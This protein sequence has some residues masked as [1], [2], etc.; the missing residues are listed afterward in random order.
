[1][2][3][4]DY[5]I[6]TYEAFDDYIDETEP[7][8][9]VWGVTWSPSVAFERID[10]IG[11]RVAMSDWLS[12]MEVAEQYCPDCDLFLWDACACDSPTQRGDAQ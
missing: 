11:Y 4:M 3:K 10:P 8:V 7:E 1:M 6:E 9:R 12:H 2:K 5:K